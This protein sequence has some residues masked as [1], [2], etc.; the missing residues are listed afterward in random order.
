M[1]KRLAIVGLL[2]ISHVVVF[3]AGRL[4]GMEIGDLRV[5]QRRFEAERRLIEPVLASD[6]AFSAV[7]AGMS[8]Y[9]GAAYLSGQVDDEAELDRL[10]SEMVRQ[11]G[12]VKV[13]EL[14][15]AVSTDDGQPNLA[16]HPDSVHSAMP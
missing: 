15:Y 7:E 1:W 2:V 6:P 14:I 13:D 9:D 11:F 5:K 3:F 4:V 8:S 16:M 12:R 10:R